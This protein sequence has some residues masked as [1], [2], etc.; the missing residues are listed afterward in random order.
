MGLFFGTDYPI[1]DYENSLLVAGDEYGKS[2]VDPRTTN[3][4][5]QRFDCCID[6]DDFVSY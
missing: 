5:P 1:G 6:G 3:L 4:N 2:C